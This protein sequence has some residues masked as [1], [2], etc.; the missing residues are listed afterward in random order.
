MV[1]LTHLSLKNSVVSHWLAHL[2]EQRVDRFD[3][4][5]RLCSVSGLELPLMCLSQVELDYT[6]HSSLSSAK[7]TYNNQMMQ[8][9]QAMYHY[10]WD[11]NY[12]TV[13]KCLIAMEIEHIL[14]SLL[15]GH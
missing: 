5:L 3:G 8:C 2:M 4:F 10:Y 6:A 15:L 9:N 14:L 1:F 11:I 13:F 7:C 12:V